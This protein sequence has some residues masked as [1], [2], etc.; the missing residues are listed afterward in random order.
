MHRVRALSC[1]PNSARLRRDDQALGSP[2]EFEIIGISEEDAIG[3]TLFGSVLTAS[4]VFQEQGVPPTADVGIVQVEEAR[5]TT[6]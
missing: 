2:V 5:E 1:S 6:W 4:N 3:V